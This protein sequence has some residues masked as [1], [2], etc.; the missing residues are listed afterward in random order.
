ML[1]IF[2]LNRLNLYCLQSLIMIRFKI[3]NDAAGKYRRAII[4]LKKFKDFDYCYVVLVLEKLKACGNT[5]TLHN[6]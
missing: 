4:F 2:V 5:S 6:Q 1:L 3:E